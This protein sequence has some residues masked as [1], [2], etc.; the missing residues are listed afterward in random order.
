MTDEFVLKNVKPVNRL[1]LVYD[2]PSKSND[3]DRGNATSPK[4][5]IFLPEDYEP[6]RETGRY[7]Y[8]EFV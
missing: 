4:L 2:P 3:E 5:E 7:K 1:V 6:H 8:M